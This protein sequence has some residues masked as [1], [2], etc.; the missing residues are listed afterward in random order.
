M[1]VNKLIADLQNDHKFTDDIIVEVFG[2]L[3]FSAYDADDEEVQCT[4]EEWAEV[5]K[6][7]NQVPHIIIHQMQLIAEL[8]QDKIEKRK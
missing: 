5:V 2:R 8:V 1:K 3:E 7:Y 6:E 4:E